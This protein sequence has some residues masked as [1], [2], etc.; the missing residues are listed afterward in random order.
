MREI[1][2]RAKRKLNG[3]WVTGSL[4]KGHEEDWDY[5]ISDGH[6]DRLDISKNRV[7]TKTIGQFTG[8]CDKNGVEIYEKDI[9]NF[10]VKKSQC[11]KCDH[12]VQYSIA[13]FCPGCGSKIETIDFV[14][15]ATIEFSD[16][17][18]WCLA[19]KD[20]KGRDF[21]WNTYFAEVFIEWIER[22]GNVFEH[23]HLLEK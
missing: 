6:D 10:A 23:R 1:K 21:T 18:A 2:F 7:I 17:G 13:S 22:I 9:V 4:V 11:S 20:R 12:D 8:R 19:Y 15:V 14:T 5:I 3:Y 16:K